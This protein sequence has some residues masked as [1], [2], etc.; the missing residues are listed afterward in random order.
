MPEAPDLRP[1][2]FR[3]VRGTFK[4][5]PAQ[6]QPLSA[7]SP[8][9]GNDVTPGPQLRVS[10]ELPVPP[11]Q[12]LPVPRPTTDHNPLGLVAATA[13]VLFGL[14]AL[15]TSWFAIPRMEDHLQGEALERLEEAG[16][17]GAVVELD[18]RTAT[19]SGL[20]ET[21]ANRAEEILDQEWGIRDAK[22]ETS[23][24]PQPIESIETTVPAPEISTPTTTE[25]DSSEPVPP[26]E[27]DD[28][29]ATTLPAAEP[30]PKPDLDAELAV[31]EARFNGDG[32]FAPGS[33]LV[34]LEAESILAD[35]A[36]L[37][38]QFPAA[39]IQIEGH[40][41]NQGDV[42][43][44]LSLSQARADAVANFLIGRGVEPTRLISLG[45]GENEPIAANDT[46]AGRAINRRTE[47][48]ALR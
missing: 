29:T 12:P 16:I 35:T 46:A 26:V 3:Q 40:T 4:P 45:F 20:S 42:L 10:A 32:A 25:A 8:R 14:L 37:L 38:V 30:D 34:T 21:D 22:I 6:V 33:A 44:N 1:S 18:G 17:T 7:A 41:D 28:E 23:S 13:I 48:A 24:D 39:T 27:P 43:D 5:P 9:S 15:L 36:D 47:F 19:I 2:G 31:L 11:A